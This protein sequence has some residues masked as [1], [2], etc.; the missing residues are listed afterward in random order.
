MT[1]PNIATL[2]N[3]IGKTAV[4]KI[5]AANTVIVSNP[6]SSNKVLKVNTILLWTS[7]KLSGITAAEIYFNRNSISYSIMQN[8]VL[9]GGNFG[10]ALNAGSGQ[11]QYR[12]LD[13]NFPIYLEEGDSI[14][15]TSNNVNTTVFCSYEEIS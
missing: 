11:Y 5:T 8:D 14:T 7:A 2:T 4:A 1:A 12:I 10:M 13:K 6:D 15:S 3:V 9:A